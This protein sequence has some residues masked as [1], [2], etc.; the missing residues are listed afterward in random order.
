MV[1]TGKA[2]GTKGTEMTTITKTTAAAVSRKLTQLGYLKSDGS[3]VG[4]NVYSTVKPRGYGFEI[5]VDHWGY[6][7][8]HHSTIADDLIAACYEVIVEADNVNHNGR[9]LT[10]LII[11]G[12]VEA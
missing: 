10:A 1:I 4:F 6:E 7:N 2:G 8:G 12:R 3:G 11:L 5:T 9:T